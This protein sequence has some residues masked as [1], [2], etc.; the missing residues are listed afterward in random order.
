MSLP[1]GETAHTA[2]YKPLKNIGTPGAEYRYEVIADSITDG[3]GGQSGILTPPTSL[4][5][6]PSWSNRV[7]RVEIITISIFHVRCSGR[8]V[9]ASLVQLL[10][11]PKLILFKIF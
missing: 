10:F 6:V 11:L 4:A 5:I 2:S 3:G 9:A 8:N 1:E 7:P